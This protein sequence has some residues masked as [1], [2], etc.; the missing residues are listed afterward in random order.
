MR[1]YV[2]L[3][4][5]SLTN[6]LVSYLRVFFPPPPLFSKQKSHPDRVKSLVLRSAALRGLLPFPV[7]LLLTD[8]ISQWHI[9]LQKEVS[10][11]NPLKMAHL[12]RALIPIFFS[13][14]R[15]FY[16]E[17]ASYLFPEFW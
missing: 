10:P 7:T 16:Q 6:D 13:E 2:T 14:L 8:A 9:H 11:R 12:R 3:N 15:W 1:K 17:G 4:V 5:H